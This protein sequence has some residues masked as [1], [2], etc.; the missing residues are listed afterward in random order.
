MAQWIEKRGRGLLQ[1]KRR[2]GRSTRSMNQYGKKGGEKGKRSL[3]LPW[4]NTSPYSHI[5]NKKRKKKKYDSP[6]LKR[7]AVPDPSDEKKKGRWRFKDSLFSILPSLLSGG[8]KGRGGKDLSVEISIDKE[9]DDATPKKGLKGG[10][11]ETF[12]SLTSKI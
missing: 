8:E 4:S 11:G 5:K 2:K 6:I 3:I 10:G 12:P 1:L 7:K 9:V